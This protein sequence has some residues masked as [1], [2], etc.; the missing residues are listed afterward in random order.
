MPYFINRKDNRELETIDEF[1]TSKEAYAMVREYNLT[2]PFAQY[3][4][5]RHACKAWKE[6]NM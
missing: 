4:V 5:S 2:D 6:S 1:A 3:Y